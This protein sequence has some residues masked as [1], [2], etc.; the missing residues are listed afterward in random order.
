MTVSDLTNTEY[1]AYYSRYLEKLPGGLT[2]IEGFESGLNQ[3]VE[4]FSSLPVEKHNHRYQSDKWSVKEMLQHLVDTER[5]FM[6]R[7]FRIARRD[8]TSLAG[9]DQAIYNTPSG[10]D[11]KAF[12]QVLYEYQVGRAHSICGG[13]AAY[14]G[15]CGV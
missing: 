10:A 2:L 15:C 8:T 1:D 13:R 12:D 14:L 4:F 9:F 6:Y 11:V 3:V 5:I 7:C